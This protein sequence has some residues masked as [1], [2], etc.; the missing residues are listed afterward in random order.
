MGRPALS[1]VGIRFR[2]LIVIRRA[3]SGTGIHSMWWTLCDCGH[4]SIKEGSKMRR[5]STGSCG[6]PSCHGGHV[7]HGMSDTATYRSWQQMRRRCYDKKAPSF[8]RYGG[9]GITVCD[10]WRGRFEAFVEDMGER[11]LGT[12]LDR[13]DA[14]LGYVPSNC[15]WATAVQQA[16]NKRCNRRVTYDGR[17]Q[18]IAEWARELG[19]N[20][21][22]LR[23]RIDRGHPLER[24]MRR[25]KEHA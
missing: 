12:T 1:L 18:T 3:A 13:I 4:E 17:T 14:A 24:A 8:A 16:N 6:L 21:F 5:G 2:K 7:T 10:R 20:Y 19:I 23:S 15:R 11:P 22:S 9:I 25:E